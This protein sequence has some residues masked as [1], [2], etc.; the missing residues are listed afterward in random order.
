MTV[1]R[2]F[3]GMSVAT[4]LLAVA[5][6]PTVAMLLI[7]SLQ[8][9]I[10]RSEEI[11]NDLSERGNLI[12]AALAETSTYGLVSGNVDA[13]RSA[14]RRLMDSDHSIASV[15]VLDEQRRP[16]AVVES[17]TPRLGAP[18][19]F[20]RPVRS[21]K[22][23]VD[24]FAD[25]NSPHLSEPHAQGQSAEGRTLGYVRIGM[26]VE[27]LMEAKW[28]YL[29][30]TAFVLIGA[31]GSGLVI[32]L[33]LINRVRKPLSRV[34]D[35]LRLIRQGSYA[36][37]LGPR[38]KGE[39]GELQSTITEVAHALQATTSG[40]EAAVAQRTLELRD[41]VAIAHRSN[42]EKR[43]LIVESNRRLEEE[44]QRIAVE[45][46]D[47]MNSALIVVR[48]KAQHIE[49]LAEDGLHGD[50][51]DV[52]LSSARSIA[53]SVDTLY[54]SAREIIRQLRPE[55][56]DMLGLV[57]AL[58]ELVRT[59]DEAHPACGFELVA[60]MELPELDGDL[61]ITAY[62]LAQES[63]SNAAK[64]A[65]ATHVR[66]DIEWNASAAQ[67]TMKIVDN[68]IG[69]DSK[70]SPGGS[71][72]LIGMRERVAGVGGELLLR[73]SQGNGTSVVFT[74]PFK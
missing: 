62:R 46:H 26:S 16:L 51:A 64:H 14:M 58:A 30:V 5:I 25:P 42:D 37:S 43:E 59:Y 11:R 60:P 24:V 73:T 50:N 10:S 35:A 48:L 23:L 36:I 3:R 9:Y 17:L 45:I 54:S 32:A 44:R 29:R 19:N 67:L 53:G 65:N 71:L 21:Q 38:A 15:E 49:Q 4:F 61:A 57:G 68:G 12:A 63:L 41:A 74:I 33:V 52:I 7:L 39:M 72:G 22:L 1:G 27:Q 28:R 34:L 6:A 18:V 55:T 69:F 47:S 40:L 56:I 13:L 2:S 8:L 66:V 70:A 20:E 31:A